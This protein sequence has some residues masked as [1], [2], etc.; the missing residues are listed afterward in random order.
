ML[1]SQRVNPIKSHN[2]TTFLWFSYGKPLVSL[3]NGEP[4]GATQTCPSID[5]Q[6][7][8]NRRFRPQVSSCRNWARVIQV[9][10]T[11]LTVNPIEIQNGPS[12]GSDFL[13]NLCIKPC[14]YQCFMKQLAYRIYLVGGLEHVLFF[15]IL[16]MSSSQLTNSYF[17]RRGRSTTNQI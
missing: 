15:H 11:E 10:S 1:N 8:W 12:W 14:K 5:V 4:L 13:M 7:L 17:F 9:M 2:T 3:F 16:W 6:P